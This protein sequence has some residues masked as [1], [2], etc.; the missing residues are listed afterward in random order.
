MNATAIVDVRT[1]G[2]RLHLPSIRN[3]QST[4]WVLCSDALPFILRRERGGC[5][6]WIG[7]IVDRVFARPRHQNAALVS[8]QVSLFVEE[9]PSW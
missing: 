5:T 1:G 4:I 6:R 9:P 8:G 2:E 7:E 3:L